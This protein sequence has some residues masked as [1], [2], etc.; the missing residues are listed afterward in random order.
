MELYEFTCKS[1]EPLEIALRVL[2]L[3]DQVPAFD[4]A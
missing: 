4:V 1:G 2:P 3:D